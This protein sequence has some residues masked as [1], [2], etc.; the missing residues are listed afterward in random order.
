MSLTHSFRYLY[1]GYFGK[2]LNKYQKAPR[3][4]LCST[5]DTAA[6]GALPGTQGL[7]LAAVATPA[8][9]FPGEKVSGAGLTEPTAVQHITRITHCNDGTVTARQTVYICSTDL[10]HGVLAEWKPEVWSGPGPCSTSCPAATCLWT[11]ARAGRAERLQSEAEVNEGNNNT[12]TEYQ[13]SEY[14]V[15]S[16]YRE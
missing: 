7:D 4:S 15:Y 2:S 14:W 13:R 1:G 11:E 6:A 3:V 9:S 5:V 8:A 16:Q 12:I 10:R